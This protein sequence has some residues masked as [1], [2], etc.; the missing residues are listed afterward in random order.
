MTARHDLA[1]AMRAVLR[2]QRH[3]MS[4][5]LDCPAQHAAYVQLPGASRL[6]AAV[7]REGEWRTGKGRPFLERPVAR[8][9]V[10]SVEVRHG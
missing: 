4:E 10:F 9:S 1:A 3:D 6:R 8:S 7:W 5:K 2:L